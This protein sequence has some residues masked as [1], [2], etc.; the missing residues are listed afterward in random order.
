M[1]APSTD[2][3]LACAGRAA[4]Q[5]AAAVCGEL[6]R[7][8]TNLHVIS[9]FSRFLGLTGTAWLLIEG[10]R[11]RS[12]PGFGDCDCSGSI[13]DTLVPFAISLPVAI[14]SAW[15]CQYLRR[16][17]ERCGLEMRIGTLDLLDCLAPRH[18]APGATDQTVRIGG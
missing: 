8:T 18:V 5:A 10:L 1:A 9:W 3:A 12:L 7:G 4:E 15:G 13:G 17:V 6:A 16:Q 11:V 14:F 2:C